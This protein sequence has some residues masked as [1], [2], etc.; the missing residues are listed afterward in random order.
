M[1]WKA[2]VVSLLTVSCECRTL[3][4]G[5]G[6]TSSFKPQHPMAGMAEKGTQNGVAVHGLNDIHAIGVVKE[7]DEEH[8]SAGAESSASSTSDTADGVTER[9]DADS[10]GDDESD[11]EEQ[12]EEAVTYERVEPE[13]EEEDN[14]FDEDIFHGENDLVVIMRRMYESL[15]KRLN[16]LKSRV[17]SVEQ[18]TRDVLARLTV[19]DCSDLKQ[20]T[21]T[22]GI[23]TFH[24]DHI[25]KRPVTVYCDM[26]TDGGGWT[27]VQRRRPHSTVVDFDREWHDYKM[28]F[29]NASIDY[30]VGLE[31]LYIWTNTKH[32]EIR[33]DLSD[34]EG[35]TAYAKYNRFYV[36]DE[37][38]GYRLHISGYS[39][40]AGDSL[41]NEGKRDNFTADGMMFT[42]HDED[43]D[44]S[45]E[46][47]CAKYWK[48]GGWWFNRCSWANLNGPYN[49]PG[50]GDGIGINWHMWRN[51]EY[52]RSST[53]MI[54][55]SRNP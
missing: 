11:E 29:G 1:F 19:M 44:T 26:E 10:P 54:R 35:E 28:G 46:I 39:G 32:Y 45:H 51:K 24:M 53:M 37:D 36:E 9:T 40:T 12:Q 5:R 30:W 49:E 22:S 6:P 13:P 20:G 4:G 23:Y 31:N 7:G 43:H 16:L 18:T 25:G 42:T 34:F 50:E 41:T 47:N 27:V 21:S 48:I 3:D 2:L 38:N 33:I 17:T 14:T 8:S 15:T 52:L 55:P